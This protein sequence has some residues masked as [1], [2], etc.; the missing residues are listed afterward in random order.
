MRNSK[1]WLLTSRKTSMNVLELGP[2][3]I[4][5][6][7]HHPTSLPLTST[8]SLH[9]SPITPILPVAVSPLA[10][11]SI[12]ISPISKDTKIGPN[13]HCPVDYPNRK[14]PRMTRIIV[15]V[16]PNSTS[17]FPSNSKCPSQES[18]PVVFKCIHSTTLWIKTHLLIYRVCY[19]GKGCSLRDNISF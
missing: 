8:E 10:K 6:H 14:S 11:E 12:N 5:Q 2:T 16:P 19:E 13:H 1:P 3:T 4:H 18:D 9:N 17:P 15:N 7:P